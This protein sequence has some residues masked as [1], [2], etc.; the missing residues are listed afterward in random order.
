MGV[1]VELVTCQSL[2]LEYIDNIILKKKDMKL[3]IKKK[4]YIIIIILVFVL[5][6]FVA[7]FLVNKR[8][9]DTAL[10]FEDEEDFSESAQAMLELGKAQEEMEEKYPWYFEFPIDRYNYMVVWSPETEQFRIIVKA[11][12][13]IKSYVLKNIVDIAIRDIEE[14]TG[15]DIEEE[16]YYVVFI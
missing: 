5:A 7:M 14:I 2:G 15:L 11:N 9:D 3:V 1:L 12:E 6:I 4:L 10:Y 8:K 16:D 13:N